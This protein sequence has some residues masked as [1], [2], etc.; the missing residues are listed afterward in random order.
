[1]PHRALSIT[2]TT[3]FHA[4]G[5]YTGLAILGAAYF[6]NP[7]VQAID[8]LIGAR[9]A[10]IVM[11]LMMMGGICALIVAIT[12]KHRADP[13]TSLWLEAIILW[14]LSAVLV[15]IISAVLIKY[16]IVVAMVSSVLLGAWLFGCLG[17]AVQASRELHKLNKI[18]KMPVQTVEV[19]AEPD[20]R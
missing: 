9:F 12:A 3:N 1:M 8:D 6:V 7:R 14:V 20:K 2:S 19:P 18:R 15:T 5:N 16:G 11:G 10:A 17:R 4:L 13:S